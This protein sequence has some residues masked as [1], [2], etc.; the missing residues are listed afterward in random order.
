MNR[1]PENAVQFIVEP[2]KD[3]AK[4]LQL[5]KQ[6]FGFIAFL[7]ISLSFPSAFYGPSDQLMAREFSET[8]QRYSINT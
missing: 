5:T 8:V 3:A 4:A 2:E 7:C 1:E 6:P